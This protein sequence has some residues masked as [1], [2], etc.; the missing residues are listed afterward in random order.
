[1]PRIAPG[2]GGGLTSVKW[3][4]T[5]AVGN[6]SGK[7]TIMI[8]AIEGKRF[9]TTKARHH[10]HMHNFD[11]QNS[12][13]G[14]LYLSSQ[15]TWYIETPSQWANGHRWELIDPTDIIEQ[16]RDYFDDDEIAQII[17]LAKLETE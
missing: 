16:Y 4:A 10:W 2:Q 6:P 17:E 3:P 9:E 7:K 14:D 8:I 15:G 1:L 5:P 11:G 13:H 12:H